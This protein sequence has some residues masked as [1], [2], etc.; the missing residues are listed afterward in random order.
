MTIPTLPNNYPLL[1]KQILKMPLAQASQRQ[2]VYRGDQRFTYPQFAERVHRLAGALDALGAKMGTTVAVM[3]WDSHRYLES[4]FAVPMSG[5]V[6]MTA[7][8]RLSPEQIAYTLDHSGAE[9]LLIH[10]DFLPILA[11]IRTRLP[12]LR[13]LVL[14][15]DAPAADIS[16]PD[17]FT[18]DYE[19]LLAAAPAQRDF[20][21]F[22]ENTQATTFYTTG[23]TGLPKG[24][25]FSHRQIVLHTLGVMATLLMAGLNAKFSRED[26]YMPLTP[27]FHVHAWGFPFAA[28]M[29][30]MQQIYVGRFLPEVVLKLLATEHVTISHC[31]PTIMHMILNAP[32]AAAID[33]SGWHVIIGGSALPRALCE[34]AMARG[35]DIFSGYGMS[36][37]CPLMTMSQL[38]STTLD[39]A[40]DRRDA[41][42]ATRVAA[43]LPA[44]FVEIRIVDDAMNDLPHDGKSIGEVVARSPYL[45]PGY[46]G[47]PEASEALWRGGW[48]HTGDLGMLDADGTLHIV[49][50]LKDVVKTG[51]E[52]VSSIGIEDIILQHP[53]IAEVAVVGVPDER[54]G[55][56]PVAFVVARPGADATDEAIKAH[57]RVRADSGE[58]SR[59]AVPDRVVFVE[60]LDKTSVGKL[61]KK[62]MRARLAA[63]V[64]APS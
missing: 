34:A 3:D 26:V 15:T 51:G 5:C 64:L 44:V 47:N 16:L 29:M 53:A 52:W 40:P 59:Y 61:D 62:A 14:L 24:V 30:G 54:W 41:E 63:S 12:K 22:D 57:V 37:T 8:I 18:G 25:M 43:G 21:D 32:A 38:R 19:S 58:I 33:L 10:T 11:A 39:A 17:G 46:A 20:P 23:T 4:Y 42:I 27:M 55:E 28:T 31:V 9:I 13:H 35:I 7:N 49:D 2:I 36:E 48:L 60:A 45:T 56:R 1:I 50:R 6:L